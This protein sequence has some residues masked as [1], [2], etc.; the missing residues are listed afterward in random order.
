V[1]VLANP[2]RIKLRR[3]DLY[4]NGKSFHNR[5]LGKTVI[6]RRNFPWAF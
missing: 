1:S 3:S 5:W 6:D 4:K 2:I